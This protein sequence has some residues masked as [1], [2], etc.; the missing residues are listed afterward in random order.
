MLTFPDTPDRPDFP[1]LGLECALLAVGLCQ[2]TEPPLDQEQRCSHVE[3][4]QATA[5]RDRCEA[6]AATSSLVCWGLGRFSG[7]VTRQ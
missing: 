3:T 2:D 1:V 6:N 5:E 7:S 4:R